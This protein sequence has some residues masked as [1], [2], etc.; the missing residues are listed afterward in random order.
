MVF[1]FTACG[2]S[3]SS[4]SG[5]T[6]ADEGT[7]VIVFAA[8][9]M[10]SSLEELEASFEEANPG[11]DIVL[12]CDSSGTLQEQIMEGAPCD[13]SS[14]QPRRTWMSWKQRAWLLKAPVPTC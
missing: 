4:E 1:A 8:A 7:E 12:N 5:E 10:Q 3:E 11:V 9:S 14:A 2:G 6:P 13:I